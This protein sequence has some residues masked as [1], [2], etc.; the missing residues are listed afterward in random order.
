MNSFIVV[1]VWFFSVYGL[2]GV[3]VEVENIAVANERTNVD[4]NL[5][6]MQSSVFYGVLSESLV[7]FKAV[8]KECQ[9]D[10]LQM[11]I[12]VNTKELW[13]IKGN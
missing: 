2:V 5:S 8:N 10:M 11:L 3:S 9:Q 6:L 13:A 1:I 7:T 4:V 12:G